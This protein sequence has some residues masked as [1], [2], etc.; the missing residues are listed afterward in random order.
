[1]CRASPLPPP[2]VDGQSKN[3]VTP[4]DPEGCSVFACLLCSA[5]DSGHPC[6]QPRGIHAVIIHGASC[7]STHTPP[8]THGSTRHRPPPQH[9]VCS[10]FVPRAPSEASYTKAGLSKAWQEGATPEA[11]RAEDTGGLAGTPM[12]SSLRV[13]ERAPPLARAPSGEDE[14]G[15]VQAVPHGSSFKRVAY[16]KPT[17]SV[18]TPLQ[19]HG[20]GTSC[21]ST[22]SVLLRGLDTCRLCQA[23][24]PWRGAGVLQG[25]LPL[26]RSNQDGAKPSEARKHSRVP[27]V[28]SWRCPVGPC[29]PR[30]LELLQYGLDVSCALCLEGNIASTG[31]W[32]STNGL[33]AATYASASR[34]PALPPLLTQARFS[35]R[36]HPRDILPIPTTSIPS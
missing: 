17:I 24:L 25:P 2:T 4:W 21:K 18:A 29:C 12:Y 31:T 7:K 26:T 16:L 27:S 3:R 15:Q 20:D 34:R 30:V 32:P 8:V 36:R 9:L 19:K 5:L 11:W 22:L 6:Q 33:G 1:M 35:K 14:P 28:A 23:F 10:F 13:G